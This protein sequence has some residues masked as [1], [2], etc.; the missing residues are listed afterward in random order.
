MMFWSVDDGMVVQS[1]EKKKEKI[2]SQTS[3]YTDQNELKIVIH[4]T[5]RTSIAVT[6]PKIEHG[7]CEPSKKGSK[8]KT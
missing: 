3:S 6:F 8:K 7:N 4:V 1:G 5:M 2:A